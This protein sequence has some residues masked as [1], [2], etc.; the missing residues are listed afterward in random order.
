MR[1]LETGELT[2]GMQTL[3]SNLGRLDQC[4]YPPYRDYHLCQQAIRKVMLTQGNKFIA[5]NKL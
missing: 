4:L 2:R 3:M 1:D 5:E